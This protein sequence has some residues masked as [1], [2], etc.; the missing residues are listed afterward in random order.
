MRHLAAVPLVLLLGA[1]GGDPPTG[2]VEITWDRDVCERCSMA[3]S[4]RRYAAQVRFAGDRQAHVFDDLGCALLWLDEADAGSETSA[5]IWVRGPSGK[6]WID[7]REAFF[8]EG[9]GT[10]M[11]YGFGTTASTREGLR[12]AQVRERVRAVEDERRSPRR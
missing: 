6:E 7:A 2:P 1:C 11:S 3:I 10:P 9:L 4:D 5:E 12:M 8:S